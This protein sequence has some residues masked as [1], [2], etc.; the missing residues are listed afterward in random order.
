MDA[1]MPPPVT[2]DLT[3][4]IYRRLYGG[5][6]TGRRINAVSVDAALLF[7]HLH[8]VADDFGNLIGDADLVRTEAAP[9]RREWDDAKIEAM[10]TELASTTPPLIY[11]YQHNGGRYINIADFE[12]NQPA[13]KNGKR[14]Q[15][16]PPFG[17]NPGESK[18]IQVNPGESGCARKILAPDTDTDSHTEAHT[19]TDA[20]ETDSTRRARHES[21]SGSAGRM[22]ARQKWLLAISPLWAVK[23]TKQ[24]RGDM[25][26]SERFFDDLWPDDESGDEHGP[27]LI[28]E[29]TKLIAASAGS[30]C[31][32][33]Y[34]TKRIKVLTNGNGV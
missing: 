1:T 31:P 23:G 21:E 5:M 16:F 27:G 28:A 17:V 12:A 30:K 6:R 19:D 18:I 14:I 4:G 26:C 10:L 15:R 34:V 7:W 29:A 33:A 9:R 2:T 22:L 3:R 24:R 11:I 8:T 20:T 32:M 25:T 13:G